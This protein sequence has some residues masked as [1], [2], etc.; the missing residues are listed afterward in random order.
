M[1][2]APQNRQNGTIALRWRDWLTAKAAPNE[3]GGP[4]LASLSE[5]VQ[6]GGITA[7]ITEPER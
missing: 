1:D 2:I 5:V 3:E 6:G 4:T 7:E